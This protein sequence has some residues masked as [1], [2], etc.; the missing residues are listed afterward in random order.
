[1]QRHAAK[2]ARLPHCAALANAWPLRNISARGNGRRL[3]GPPGRSTQTAAAAPLHMA[4][5]S[6]SPLAVDPRRSSLRPN[7][8]RQETETAGGVRVAVAEDSLGLRC[9][10]QSLGAWPWPP[11]SLLS[12]CERGTADRTSALC[13][14]ARASSEREQ[15]SDSPLSLCSK[16]NE[17]GRALVSSMQSDG[18]PGGQRAQ[19]DSR[20][21][22]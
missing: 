16:G 6:I 15:C 9:H 20:G 14:H 19:M 2:Q 13:D 21:R 10:H 7:F 12:S 11:P 4:G 1:M 8:N 18:R 22:E 3:A 17:F 5:A